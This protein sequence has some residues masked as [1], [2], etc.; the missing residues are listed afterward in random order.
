MDKSEII[1]F[2]GNIET[3]EEYK[4]LV[5]EEL[6]RQIEL[7]GLT[8]HFEGTNVYDQFADFYIQGWINDNQ[9]WLDEIDEKK[10]TDF[11]KEEIGQYIR[12]HPIIPQDILELQFE[13]KLLAIEGK[14]LSPDLKQKIEDYNNNP[15]LLLEENARNLM[16]KNNQARISELME[17]F[18][19]SSFLSNLD[20]VKERFLI[21]ESNPENF[22]VGRIGT[23]S[24]I[25]ENT[26]SKPSMSEQP[27][28]EEYDFDVN[29]RQILIIGLPK[30]YPSILA[31]FPDKEYPEGML[32]STLI[33]NE[34]NSAFIAEATAQ[35]EKLY[36]KYKGRVNFDKLSREVLNRIIQEHL[37]K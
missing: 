26:G 16:T 9:R 5:I 11:S 17:Y 7:R 13:E 12:E 1:S 31:Y 29:S 3:Y 23:K 27:E 35:M 24:I 30:D 14:E 22:S 8:T 25:T 18:N 2:L 20:R 28:G 6:K 34:N 32:R 33:Q 37:E 10:N 36:G 21:V 19:L 4:K 15:R